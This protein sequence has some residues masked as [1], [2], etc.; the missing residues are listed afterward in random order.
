MPLSIRIPRPLRREHHRFAARKVDDL[1]SQAIAL[2][3]V[4]LG[5]GA[6]SGGSGLGRGEDTIVSFEGR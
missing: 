6:R 2:T 3:L 4:R 5:G 1:R